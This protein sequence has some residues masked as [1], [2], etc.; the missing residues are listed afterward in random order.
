MSA[1]SSA[2]P[3]VAATAQAG[4]CCSPWWGCRTKHAQLE[5]LL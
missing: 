2:R 5:A 4:Q 1:A 3:F